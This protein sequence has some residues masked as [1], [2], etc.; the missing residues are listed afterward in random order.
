SP[1]KYQMLVIGGGPAGLVT[2]AAAAGLGAKTALI[3]KNLLG[4]DCLNV[5]CV[6]SKA[7]IHSS[8][9]AALL[10]EAR[11]DGQLKGEIADWDF[12]RVMSRMRSLR[13]ELAPHDSAQRFRDLG[14]DVYFGE[15]RF[16]DPSSVRVG[17]SILRFGK[18]CLA[19]GSSPSLP[20]IPGIR[21]SCCLTN[22]SIFSLTE[23]PEKL[24]VVGG[25]PIGCELSQ[26]FRR[27]GSEVTVFETQTG[28][29]PREE[30][31]A[32]DLV[33]TQ[34]ESDGCLIR[35]PSVLLSIATRD[36]KRQ[37]EFEYR[38]R[39]Q[40]EI[41]DEILVAAGRRPNVEDLG[42]DAAG[43]EFDT[44]KGIQVDPC[45]RTTNSHVFAAGDV[46]A[47][48]QAFTHA[49]DFMARTVVQNALFP[50]PRKKGTGMV[51]PRAI[52]TSPELA[53]VGFTAEEARS[54][55]LKFDSYELPFADVDRA[56]LDSQSNGFIRVLTARGKDR[57]LGATIVGHR[58]SELIG[59]FSMAITNRIGLSGLSASIFPYPTH[60]EAI[61][62]MGD[63]YQKSRLTP[64][65]R[66]LLKFWF[67]SRENS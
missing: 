57:I 24:A 17:D 62:K 11:R 22:E 15:A 19:T 50:G 31:D 35:A 33:R 9:L 53:Q 41:Y 64:F 51:I 54:G 12:S 55:K 59:Y 38:A 52:Y 39:K 40:V 5:G 65:K 8:N 43:I 36:G 60:A 7:L 67:G 23:L 18:A 2:A 32:A 46:V 14:V 6:P 3:E 25:G 13:A 47:G 58:A 61:R 44:R 4:G 21:K 10:Q 63:L 34:M 37:I 49:A 28:I 26:C 29:L 45:F 16:L 48:Q 66:R 27:L 20:D 56:V 42:L 30:Q 1:G